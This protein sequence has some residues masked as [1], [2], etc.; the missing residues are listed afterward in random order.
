MY[1]LA[2]SGNTFA[3][4]RII[5]TSLPVAH[6]EWIMQHASIHGSPGA[7]SERCSAWAWGMDV[8]PGCLRV[9]TKW[10]RELTCVFT[11]SCQALVKIFLVSVPSPAPQVCVGRV[12]SRRQKR[13]GKRKQLLAVGGRW[14]Q[15]V[16]LTKARG[17]KD[18]ALTVAPKRV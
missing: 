8:D 6:A 16:G 3:S 14:L 9:P 18:L 4:Q 5:S 1:S 11:S 12:G 2:S 15:C 10:E 13:S 17:D 7:G